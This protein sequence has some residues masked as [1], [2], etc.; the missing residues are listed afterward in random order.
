MVT[1][2]ALIAP[3]AD[4]LITG[5]HTFQADVPIDSIGEWIGTAHLGQPHPLTEFHHAPAQVRIFSATFGTPLLPGGKFQWAQAKANGIAGVQGFE[6]LQCQCDK[7]R[8]IRL[9]HRRGH[10]G[11]NRCFD[12]GRSIANNGAHSLGHFIWR[13][14]A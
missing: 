6:F 11:E 7:A 3:T 4:A 2:S 12:D 9:R 5:L 8:L 1:L 13:A 14:T 10:D